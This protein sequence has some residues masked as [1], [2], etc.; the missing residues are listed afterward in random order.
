MIE[1]V[2][3]NEGSAG[4]VVMARGARTKG[5]WKNVSIRGGVSGLVIEDGANLELVEVSTLLRD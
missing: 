3:D 4:N 5:L 1:S 2:L